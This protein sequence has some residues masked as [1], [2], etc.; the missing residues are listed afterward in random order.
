M[1]AL[2]TGRLVMRKY[3]SADKEKFTAVYTNDVVMKY[4]T[5]RALTPAE[6]TAQYEQAIL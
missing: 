2:S 4:I 3:T 1:M 6:A 5:G